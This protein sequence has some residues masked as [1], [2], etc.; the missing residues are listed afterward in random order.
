MQSDSNKIAGADNGWWMMNQLPD[1][2]ILHGVLPYMGIDDTLDA[3]AATTPTASHAS[4]VVLARQYL[5]LWAQ[6]MSIQCFTYFSDAK[7]DLERISLADAA[8]APF[9]VHSYVCGNTRDGKEVE[10]MRS[11]IFNMR[12]YV[13]CCI[14]MTDA[15]TESAW[16]RN[17]L[18]TWTVQSNMLC[19]QSCASNNVRSGI[20]EGERVWYRNEEDS[21]Y[22]IRLSKLHIA[23]AHMTCFWAG[24][25]DRMA[26]VTY[27]VLH[28]EA[29]RTMWFTLLAFCR[30]H[31]RNVDD[32]EPTE[33]MCFALMCLAPSDRT[34]QQWMA[35]VETYK[36]MAASAIPSACWNTLASKD[37]D[38][39][40]FMTNAAWCKWLYDFLCSYPLFVK[41]VHAKELR[42]RQEL[43]DHSVSVFER[44]Q[45]HADARALLTCKR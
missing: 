13:Y 22:F 39:D 11:S 34:W 1:D 32:L 26:W 7:S 17:R 36:T 29:Q 41:V 31:G 43:R 8:Q 37:G 33:M 6:R 18:C 28:N 25:A 12:T 14:R 10:L 9:G 35:H 44:Y 21:Y 3:A 38:G 40:G 30:A 19:D 16:N 24:A 2:L 45:T 20:L 4:W 42:T 27:V 15:I 23:P 5:V